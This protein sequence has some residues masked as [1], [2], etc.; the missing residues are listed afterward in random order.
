[1]KMIARYN[2]DGEIDSLGDFVKMEDAQKLVDY[3]YEVMTSPADIAI[4]LLMER[5]TDVLE[6]WMS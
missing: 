5:G 1:M 4:D 6:E 2:T 3:L